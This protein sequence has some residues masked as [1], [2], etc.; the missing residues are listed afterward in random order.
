[1]Q[2]LLLV[3]DDDRIRLSEIDQPH[4]KPGQA[5]VKLKAAALNR[6]DEWCR[7]GKYPG[8]RFGAVLGSD[9]AGIVEDVADPSDQS[10]VGKE[11]VINPNNLWGENPA[12]QGPDY[13]IL[14]MPNNGTF[15]EY[16]AVNVDR[17]NLKPAHLDFVYAAA[18]PLAGLTAYRAVFTQG[19]IAIGQNV[20][21][22]GIGGGVAQFCFQFA[23]AAG[24]RVYVSSSSDEKL[25]RVKSMGAMGGFDY[26]QEDW[27]K[28]ATAES[29]GFD[30]VIDSSGGDQ[31]NKL[32]N[33][34]KPGGR[35]VFF[36]ATAGGPNRLD[37]FK[38]FW[39]QI[40]MQGTSMGTDDE[41]EKMLGFV[42]EHKIF[43][44]V[45][46]VRPLAD[47]VSAF[48]QMRDSQQLGKLVIQI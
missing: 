27:I 19:R 26:T 11:V 41:F 47:I 34:I 25:E 36:G 21:V 23:A 31:F 4:P 48:D 37:L 5:L 45:D 16:I 22:T 43:P 8:I 12:A 17:L 39:K 29:G 7:Q 33:L 42:S 6:R 28:R 2:A 13:H 40:T 46:S 38:I 18:C 1:M 24:A 44:V 20:L 3:E 15:A 10:W 14:G 9:G 32:L 35:L 30:L